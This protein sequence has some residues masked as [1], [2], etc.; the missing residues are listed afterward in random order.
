MYNLYA[1]Q[2]WQVAGT[3]Y[4]FSHNKLLSSAFKT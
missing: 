3:K 1:L 2:Y 4:I